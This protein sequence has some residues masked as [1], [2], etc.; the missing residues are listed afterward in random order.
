KLALYRATGSAFE[1]NVAAA[2]IKAKLGQW[3]LCFAEFRMALAQVS[4]DPT[5]WVEFGRT[6]ELAG[7][8]TTAREAYAEAARLAPTDAQ[9]AVAL[10]RVEA[11]Q[12]YMR[13]IGSLA[14][15]APAAPGP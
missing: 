6:A 5:L 8:D 15:A 9:I 10:R 13:G 7:R 11:R 3:N 2:H 4:G 1:A 12:G 14:P